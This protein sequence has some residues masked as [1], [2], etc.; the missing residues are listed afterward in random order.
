MQLGCLPLLDGYSDEDLFACLG[1][2]VDIYSFFGALK[3]EPL[4]RV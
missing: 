1:V 2:E 4:G 3:L